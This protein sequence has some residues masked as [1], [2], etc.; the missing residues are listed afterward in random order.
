LILSKKGLIL[1]IFRQKVVWDQYWRGSITSR[2]KLKQCSHCLAL[3]ADTINECPEDNCVLQPSNDSKHTDPLIGTSL[4][5]R[6]KIISMVG[7]GGMGIVYKAQHL[8][9]ERMVAVKFL[10]AHLAARPNALKR[11]HS[12]AK[13]IA[14]LRHHNIINLYDFGISPSNQPFLVM[15]YIDGFSLKK[16]VD[17]V[18]P[19]PLE[20]VGPILRQVVDGL[21]YAH[22]ENVVHR[23]LKP[24]N[25]MLTKT[26][27]GSYKVTLV[28]FGLAA[29]GMEG[30]GTP[31]GASTNAG[32]LGSPYYMS[33]EQCLSNTT[34]DSRSDIYSLAVVL[35][36][37]LSGHLPYEKKSG[38]A[39]LETHLHKPPMP[40][41]LTQPSLKVCTELT[42][43]FNQA[44]AKTVDDRYQTINDF[45]TEMTEALQRDIGKWR[46]IRH[47][48]LVARQTMTK[49][50]SILHQD[51]SREFKFD[52]SGFQTGSKFLS[53]QAE[54]E[55]VLFT[56]DKEN[57]A[58]KLN[59]I[60]PASEE[61]EKKQCLYC[62]AM[63][64][65]GIQF[66]LSCQRKIEARSNKLSETYNYIP[67][68]ALDSNSRSPEQIEQ[69]K[70]NIRSLRHNNLSTF[71]VK[72]RKV[73][74][75]AITSVLLLTFLM[76][77]R[78]YID[79]DK[80]ARYLSQFVNITNKPIPANSSYTV[81]KRR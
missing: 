3:F 64:P 74:M 42:R 14:Q 45:A 50:A 32:L 44:L 8:V 19:I 2:L 31:T 81:R 59:A 75:Y 65:A 9:M 10:H 28:D 17:K 58:D 55:A 56:S 33:P 5:D 77:C 16:L 53:R 69:E 43:V 25:I 13:T 12:E 22:R 18:G 38:M 23:D 72:T 24:E 57:T 76:L 66:C 78:T 21:S 6:Y 47:R 1:Y 51:P 4:A 79:I 49:A 71:L 40:F 70:S 48:T 37:A 60:D 61:L 80:S 11:F 30:V 29:F 34:V 7:R 39:M 54:I 36:E 41:N 68:D 26:D 52:E 63:M 46:A 35:Y 73:L 20:Q 62:G 67:T 15:D 27:Q